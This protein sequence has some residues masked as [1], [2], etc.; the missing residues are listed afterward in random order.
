MNIFCKITNTSLS[1]SGLT[2]P[3]KNNDTKPNISD[4]DI[5]RLSYI[6]FQSQSYASFY[7]TTMEKDKSILTLSVAGI[8]FLVTVLNISKAINYIH[9][10]LFVVAAA[11]FLVSIYCVLTIFEKNADFII[12]LTQKRDV[13]L[14]EYKLKRLDLW[15]IRSFYLAI[16]LST[17]LGISTTIALIKL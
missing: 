5:K 15:A 10:T 12:D 17:L 11:L 4:E 8:G 7:S 9:Y 3:P 1:E 16:L 2:E 13:T 6:E 14:K